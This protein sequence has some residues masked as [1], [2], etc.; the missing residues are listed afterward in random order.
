M[1]DIDVKALEARMSDINWCFSAELEG[2][3]NGAS[4]A[5][6]AKEDAI[7]SIVLELNKI[8]YDIEGELIADAL[9]MN[10]WADSP[11]EARI[12]NFSPQTNQYESNQR[13][14]F[15]VGGKEI[16]IDETY[17]FLCHR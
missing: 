2:K 8:S 15:I 11:M 7:E 17:R 4:T 10:F 12:L 13:F 5:G 6:S 3:H 16:T 1:N 14:Y 9:K